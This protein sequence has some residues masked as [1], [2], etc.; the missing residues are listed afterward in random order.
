MPASGLYGGPRR[1][2]F[3]R[4]RNMSGGI[5]PMPTRRQYRLTTK[6]FVWSSE[7]GESYCD[8]IAPQLAGFP[9]NR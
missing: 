9:A 1:V 3:E 2:S 4:S 5:A 8:D 7:S 6:S